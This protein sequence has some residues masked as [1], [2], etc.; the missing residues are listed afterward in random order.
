MRKI[1]LVWAVALSFSAVVNAA[2][3]YE[4]Q[5][6]KA[7]VTN[8]ALGQFTYP[9]EA[10]VKVEVNENSIKAYRPE[11][12]FLISPPLATKN[13]QLLMADDGSK[14]Y[15]AAIDNSNFAITDRIGKSTEQ[16]DK[17]SIAKSSELEKKPD[18][19]IPVSEKE[20]A[21]IKELNGVDSLKCA[22]YIDKRF[23]LSKNKIYKVKRDFLNKT[24]FID[25]GEITCEVGSNIWNWDE[26]EV[27]SVENGVINGSNYTIYHSDGS[28]SVGVGD[29]SWSF[30]CSKDA[31]TDKKECSM[32]NKEM[33]IYKEAKGYSVVV[34]SE[35]FPGRRS[36]IRVGEG[37][38]SVGSDHGYFPGASGIISSIT[39]NSKLIVRYTKWPYDY[40]I[41]TEINTSN[42]EQAKYIFDRVSAKY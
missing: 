30:G 22:T 13:G 31:I 26:T 1:L 28:G 8:G 7:N 14:V 37:K 41:D 15:A 21:L 9:Y 40:V 3:V 18:V 4:C 23:S 29:A 10:R 39:N 16:W 6:T 35:H 12:A 11:G 36:Y 42:F 24:P 27:M 33:K 17:C 19:G 20:I 2:E 38:A 5:Y 32:Y 34:G 25:G